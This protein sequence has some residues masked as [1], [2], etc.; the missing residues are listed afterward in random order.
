MPAPA[1]L[2][3]TTSPLAFFGAELRKFRQ[4][5]G[6]SQ[7]DLANSISFSA[8][9]I[10]FVER[11]QRFPSRDFAERCDKALESNG[12]LLR[13]W[14]LLTREASPPWFHGWL[15]V[16]HQAHTLRT[17]QPLVVPGLLQTEEYAHA[18]IGGEPRITEEDVAKRLQARMERQTILAR[19]KPPL[20]QVVLDECV[21]LRPIGGTDVMRRQLER[22]L[23]AAESPSISIQVVPLMLGG[24]A[25]ISGGFVIAQLPARTD[26]V[27]IESA[28]YGY[29]TSHSR[30][31]D[32][33]HSRYDAIRIEACPQH[34][35]IDR[36]RE[37]VRAWS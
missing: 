32:A 11:A 12:E 26:T 17:W 35:S 15:D 1:E 14:P 27:Y 2:D 34:A 3:P 30:D 10:G 23:S 24:T 25:G 37:A 36:I 9:L 8:S 31:V 19:D 22:L 7:E 18:V 5:A 33:I 16:E 28:N 13:L 29:V 20:L 6:V 21:L 4:R